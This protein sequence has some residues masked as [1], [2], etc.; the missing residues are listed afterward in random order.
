MSTHRRATAHDFQRLSR[1]NPCG[2]SFSYTNTQQGVCVYVCVCTCIYMHVYTYTYMYIRC[3]YCTSYIYTCSV[4]RGLSLGTAMYY[5]YVCVI[6]QLYVSSCYYTCVYVSSSY[7]VHVLI[8]PHIYPI[9]LHIHTAV[10]TNRKDERLRKTLQVRGSPSNN[11]LQNKAVS[12][13]QAR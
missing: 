4:P 9:L 8:P 3:M 10:C 6:I 1:A 2:V 11:R 5:C 13:C 7:Y 12:S